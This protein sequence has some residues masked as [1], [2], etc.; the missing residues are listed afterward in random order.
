ME[1]SFGFLKTFTSDPQAHI[2][3]HPHGSRVDLNEVS[4]PQAGPGT[5][6][7]MSG[8]GSGNIVILG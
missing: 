4:F 6:T 5:L 8:P 2:H 3:S 1:T 7:P